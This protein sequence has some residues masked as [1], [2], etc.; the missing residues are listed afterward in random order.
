[1]H[2]TVA[3][4]DPVCHGLAVYMHKPTI[5]AWEILQGQALHQTIAQVMSSGGQ[6]LIR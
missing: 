2:A 6:L 4:M 1:M 3:A 5:Q